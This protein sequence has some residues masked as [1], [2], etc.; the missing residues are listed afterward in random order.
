M[1]ETKSRYAVLGMLSIAPMSGYDIKKRVGESISNFWTESYGQIYPILKSL[2]AEKL[3]TKTVEKGEGKPDRHVYALT[4]RGRKELQRWLAENVTPKVDRNELLL[5]LF[6]GEEVPF[7]TNISH[8]EQYRELQRG[9]LERYKAIEKE[10][11]AEYADNPNLPYWLLTVRYGQHVSQAL[12][13]WCDEAQA[14]LNKLAKS[15]K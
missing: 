5:K 2:V 10:I 11:K 6:F 9:L 8:I 14:K 7:D 3:V 13:D 12:L 4:D 1:R 15:R